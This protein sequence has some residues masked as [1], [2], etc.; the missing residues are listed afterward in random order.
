MLKEALNCKNCL[1][2]D[3][4]EEFHQTFKNIAFPNTKKPVTREDVK[5]IE[6]YA[7]HYRGTSALFTCDNHSALIK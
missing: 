7:S 3:S 2:A 1:K 5:L 6:R 4:C